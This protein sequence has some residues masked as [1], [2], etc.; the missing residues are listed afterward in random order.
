[1][2]APLPSLKASG[3]W[4]EMTIS[5]FQYYRGKAQHSVKPLSP[6]LSKNTIFRKQTLGSGVIRRQHNPIKRRTQSNPMKRQREGW[7]GKKLKQ[8]RFAML[9][10]TDTVVTPHPCPGS[11]K[12]RLQYEY[13]HRNCHCTVDAVALVTYCFSH[14]PNRPT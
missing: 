9:S 12:P 13:T 14:T 3:G 6:S 4:S 2:S 8:Q 5:H 7:A 1:M 10:S 11:H